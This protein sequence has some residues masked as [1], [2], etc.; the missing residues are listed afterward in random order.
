VITELDHV[1]VGVPDLEAGTEW[2]ERVSGVRA[3]PGGSHAG[4]GTHNALASL[5]GSLYLELIAVDPSQ[6]VQSP[7]RDW[8]AALDEPRP[9]S[10]CFGCDDAVAT[11][12]AIR[13]AGV[14][15]AVFPLTRTKPAGD[16]LTWHLVYP[17]HDLGPA[18]PYLID[19]GNAES[20]AVGAPEGCRLVSAT[21]VHPDPPAAQ[22]TLGALGLEIPVA[23]GPESGLRLRFETPKGPLDLIS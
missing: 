3:A 10:W 15:A 2:W 11:H 8:L 7:A 17:L 12:E 20:P 14:E 1:A 22:Q 19:W 23:R 5:G 18:I 21:P 9:F 13:A 16:A 6:E 4:L